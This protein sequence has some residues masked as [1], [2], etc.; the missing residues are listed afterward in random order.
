MRSKLNLAIPNVLEW[1]NSSSNPVGNEYI[2]Q[3]HVA[4]EL[5]HEKWA[6]MNTE[7]HMLC[8]KALSLLI[9]KMAALDFPAYGSL[10]FSDAPLPSEKKVPFEEG[11]CVGPHCGPVYWNCS[12]GELDLYGGPSPNCGPCKCGFIS[13]ASNTSHPRFE[14]DWLTESV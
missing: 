13:Y 12:P 4:G 5:L 1:N 6:A 10:Y 7:Q 11:Y 2:I 9:R 8:T 14:D 3:E